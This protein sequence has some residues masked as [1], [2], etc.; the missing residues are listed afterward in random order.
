[1]SSDSQIIA[2]IENNPEKG[3]RMLLEKFQEQVYWHIR[4]M[5]V[6]HDDAQDATQETF[7]RVFKS[8]NQFNAD[9]SLKT[10][11]FQIATNEAIRLLG[12]NKGKITVSLDETTAD[13]LNLRADDFFDY[14]DNLTVKLQQAIHALPIKQQLAFN[15]RYYDE[16]S[17][18][19]IANITGFTAANVKANYHF[20]KEKI[21]QFMNKNELL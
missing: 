2:A 12:R 17:Y 16:M 5:V 15:F 7:L 1:M 6:A 4:R 13:I 21:I 20:A 10:W 18:E 8:F 9:Y 14:S 3:F 11:I 19:E